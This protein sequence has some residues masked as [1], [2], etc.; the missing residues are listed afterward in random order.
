MGPGFRQDDSGDWSASRLPV[1]QIT[2][3]DFDPCTARQ[4]HKTSE[5]HVRQ[6]ANFPNRLNMI[7]LFKS[8]RKNKSLPFF[9]NS[10]FS[11][12]I[13]PRKRDVTANRHETWSAG[14]DGRFWAAGRA[15]RRRTAKACGPDLPTLGSSFARRFAT[16][17]GL[18]S[19]AP[20]G[21]RA[22]S[23]KPLAQGMPGMFRRTC[24]D[25]RLLFLLQAGRGCDRCTGIP[26]ALLTRGTMMMHHSGM[27]VPREC[28][29]VSSIAK[30]KLCCHAP[31]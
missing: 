25:C 16:R 14:C 22:I 1:G 17:R 13:P 7:A 30:H 11:P 6:S 27:F 5:N 21:E 12:A 29:A 19:P 28:G 31:A 20:R 24:G 18:S 8:P 15:A 4:R 2:L 3:I 26:C 9:R 23:R 10:C